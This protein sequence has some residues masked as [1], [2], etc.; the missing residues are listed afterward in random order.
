MRLL[1]KVVCGVDLAALLAFSGLMAYGFS[2][3]SVF[4]DRFDPWLRV[5][6]LVFVLGVIG[7]VA[8][9][10]GTYRLW[11]ISAKGLWSTIYSGG[12]IL[13]SL[14]FLWF[15]GAS[16]ILQPSLKY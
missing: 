4:S 9:L 13:A 15:V 12:L 16:R 11:R 8:M 14:I 5:L 6:Q 2:N 10:C 1:V 3:L 7:T